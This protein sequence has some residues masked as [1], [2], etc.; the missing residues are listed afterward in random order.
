MSEPIVGPLPFEGDK[1]PRFRNGK[2][3][4]FVVLPSLDYNLQM[5][6]SKSIDCTI[7]KL[8]R[9]PALGHG[10]IFI[11]VTHWSFLKNELYDITISH[12]PACTCRGIWYICASTLE[13][14][15]KWILCKHLYFILQNYM[16]CTFA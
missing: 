16:S 6:S 2:P 7:L 5:E 4:C 14:P 8:L 10:V 9:V 13:N 12:F 1:Q 3:F 11:V 15:K